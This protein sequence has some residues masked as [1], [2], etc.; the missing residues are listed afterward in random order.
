[1]DETDEKGLIQGRAS[2]QAPALDG[3]RLQTLSILEHFKETRK[4]IL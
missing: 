1:M 4:F 2:L 3:G